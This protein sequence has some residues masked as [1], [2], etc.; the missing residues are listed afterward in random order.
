MNLN[1]LNENLDNIENSNVLE[2]SNLSNSTQNNNIN[3]QNLFFPKTIIK[4]I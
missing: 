3:K 2:I 4:I 1:I